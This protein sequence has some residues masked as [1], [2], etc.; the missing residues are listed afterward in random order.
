VGGGSAQI[1]PLCS[2]E[3]RAGAWSRCKEG[4]SGR[5]AVT[6]LCSGYVKSVLCGL[7]FVNYFLS[8]SDPTLDEIPALLPFIWVGQSA[9]TIEV[10]KEAVVWHTK[11]SRED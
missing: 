11:Q 8:P 2:G 3:Q 1:P 9:D 6:Q 4:P 5:I 7:Y 10:C